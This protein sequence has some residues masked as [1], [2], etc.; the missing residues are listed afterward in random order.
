LKVQRIMAALARVGVAPGE[1][2]ELAVS[3]PHSR[4]RVRLAYARR[5]GRLLLGYRMR[6]SHS[7]VAVEACPIAAPGLE[8]LL[9][10]LAA[11]LSGLGCLPAAGE[12]ALTATD[13]GIDLLLQVQS[14]AGLDDRERLAAIAEAL[15]LARL[16]IA[17]DLA[18]EAEPVV[19]R[20]AAVVKLGEVAVELPPGAF[21]QATRE[22]EAVLQGFVRRWTPE[23]AGV[24]DFFAGLGT[25]SLPLAPTARKIVAV[26]GSRT[27]AAALAAAVRRARLSAMEVVARDLDRQPMTAAE[28]RRLGADHVIL[29]PP[30]GGAEAQVRELARAALASL[31]YVSC[32]P[33]TFARDARLLADDGWS[34]E[35]LQPVDQFLYSPEVELAALFRRNGD[36]P[37]AKERA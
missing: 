15:D 22:G 11:A 8:R 7:I 10:P 31:L 25:F 6:R 5:G 19:A 4:R 26:E 16:S 3:P 17:D 32:N 34:L 33:A 1:V 13:A 28:L 20:R 14:P 29:D 24:V 2:D 27:A 23:G 36:E 18:G 12:A 21:L 37:S 35:R 9:A 30:R